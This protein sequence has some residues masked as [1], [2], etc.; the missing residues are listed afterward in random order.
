[1]DHVVGGIEDP[2]ASTKKL[3][4]MSHELNKKMSAYDLKITTQD[5]LPLQIF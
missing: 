3:S 2:S 4:Q 5:V 1:M